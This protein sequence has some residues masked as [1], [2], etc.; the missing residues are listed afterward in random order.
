MSNKVAKSDLMCLSCGSIIP[1][2]N[3]MGTQRKMF[4]TKVFYC[5]NCRKHTKHVELQ[6]IDTY[7][8]SLEF[9]D[10]ETL[11]EQEMKIYKLIKKR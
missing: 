8:A 11:T 10:P 9:K 5:Q 2:W 4:Q 6:N 1:T 7:I 3:Y